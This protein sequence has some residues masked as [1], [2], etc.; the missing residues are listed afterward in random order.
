MRSIVER[1]D[2]N[3]S[4]LFVQV[5]RTDSLT[6]APNSGTGTTS[7]FERIFKE[8]VPSKRSFE[9]GQF[10]ILRGPAFSEKPSLVSTFLKSLVSKPGN[11]YHAENLATPKT[12]SGL[13]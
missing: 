3:C 11:H 12:S 13:L 2:S 1:D 9:C 6:T 7:C 10:H 5:D 8:L 4:F